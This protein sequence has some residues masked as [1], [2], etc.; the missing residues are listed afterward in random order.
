MARRVTPDAPVR[1]LIRALDA[2]IE[3]FGTFSKSEKDGIDLYLRDSDV[4][5]QMEIKQEYVSVD[6]WLPSEDLEEARSSGIARTHPFLGDDAVRIRF[7]RA[8]DL[9]RVARWA[10]ASYLRAPGRIKVSN[11]PAKAAADVQAPASEPP[12]PPADPEASAKNG[13]RP[14][15]KKP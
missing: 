11:R 8:Q 12:A 4:F 9:A 6:L 1:A 7:E 5:M 15:T 14:K 10:E 2:R 3:A 13:S